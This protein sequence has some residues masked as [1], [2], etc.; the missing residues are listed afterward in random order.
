MH[1]QTKTKT[2]TKLLAKKFLEK[3][4]ST[5]IKKEAPIFTRGS[6]EENTLIT[7]KN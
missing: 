4:K 3:D 7:T 2:K 5:E 6:I 1:A